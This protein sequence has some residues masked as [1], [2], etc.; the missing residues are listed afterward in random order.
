MFVYEKNGTICVTF[1]DNKPIESP[2]Y[3]ILIDK[4]NGILSVNGTPVTA[5]EAYKL[6]QDVIYET[7]KE[8]TTPVAINLNGHTVAIPEDTAGSGVYHVTTGGSLTI[9]GEGV[10]NGVGKNDYNMALWADGGNVIINGGTFT[11]KGATASIEPTHFDLIYAKNGS[12]VEINGGF[13]ECETPQWTLNN[14]DKNPGT[15]IVKGGTFVGFN[16]SC[17]N[18]EP[19]GANNNFVAEGYTVIQNGDN[20][21]VVKSAD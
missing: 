9:N 18:T 16:P 19:I 14:N 4:Q 3:M 15:F 21:T 20:Y 6:E 5:V 7:A 17:T 10:I 2:E 11:N 13:F 8:I 12:I 1:K